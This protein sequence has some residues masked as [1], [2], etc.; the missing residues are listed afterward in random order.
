MITADDL[1]N[2]RGLYNDIERAIHGSYHSGYR[3]RAWLHTFIGRLHAAVGKPDDADH[4]WLGWALQAVRDGHDDGPLREELRPDIILAQTPGVYDIRLGD[5][6]WY[7]V[8]IS[9]AAAS[10]KILR[11]EVER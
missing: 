1:G 3:A 4:Q 8:A 11:G 9:Q 5:G 2:L 10:Q 6:R 7:R